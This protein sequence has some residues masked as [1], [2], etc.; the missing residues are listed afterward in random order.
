M[1]AKMHAK[2]ALSLDFGCANFKT[3]LKVRKNK[4]LA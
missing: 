4:N 1:I 2:H 3:A